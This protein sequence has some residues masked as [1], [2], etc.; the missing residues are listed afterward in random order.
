METSISLVKVRP[1]SIETSSDLYIGQ[2][3]IICFQL[4]SQIGRIVT[5]AQQQLERP[6]SMPVSWQQKHV[7]CREKE[8]RG[9]SERE[10]DRDRVDLGGTH[11]H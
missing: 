11:A 8:F 6:P 7:R 3:I 2:A 9:G 1:P 10:G 5:H 4:L